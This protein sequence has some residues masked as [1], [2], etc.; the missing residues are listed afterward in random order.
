MSIKKYF[1]RYKKDLSK[2]SVNGI[3]ITILIAISIHFI[4]YF[5]GLHVHTLP[6]GKIV[7]HSHAIP[8]KEDNQGQTN[9]SHSNSEFILIN[10]LGSTF[11]RAII[12]I[13]I[14]VIIPHIL[15]F[16]LFLEKFRINRDETRLNISY[17][18]PPMF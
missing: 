9:H 13:I 14:A 5:I 10:A 3:I 8:S 6:D 1:G 17:R 16:I 15:I 7:V 18:A 4:F 12:P 11:N 2:W